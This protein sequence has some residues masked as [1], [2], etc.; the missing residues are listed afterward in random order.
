MKTL[1]E[2]FEEAFPAIA[3]VV[4]IAFC[5]AFIINEFLRNI[6]LLF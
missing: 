3:Y 5:A 4:L 2:E 6:K 1:K